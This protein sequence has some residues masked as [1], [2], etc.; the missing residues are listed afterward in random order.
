MHTM[1]DTP[2]TQDP[3]DQAAP[4]SPA[5]DAEHADELKD[6]F[7]AALERKRGEAKARSAQGHGAG[8]P[9]VG[10]SHRKAGGKRTFRRK[11]G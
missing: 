8:S 4:A 11:S 5:E 3:S 1:A 10:E 6:R 9:K 7:R 2:E